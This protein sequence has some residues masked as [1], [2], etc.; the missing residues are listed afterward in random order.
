MVT[1]KKGRAAAQSKGDVVMTPAGQDAKVKKTINKSRRRKATTAPAKAAPE[2][3][4][5]RGR[6]RVEKVAS[7]CA[8]LQE[9]RKRQAE[10]WKSMKAKVAALKKDR[11]KLPTRGSKEKRQAL[12]QDIRRLQE[13]MQVR[14]MAELR[15]A[16]LEATTKVLGGSFSGTLD[17]LPCGF[18]HSATHRTKTSKPTRRGR[19][20]CHSHSTGPSTSA[21]GR[22]GALSTAEV[23]Q[24]APLATQSQPAPSR[25]KVL[26]V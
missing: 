13:D 25:K 4:R 22:H 9:L 8:V 14:H 12:N 26:L 19:L 1:R 21:A 16:G 2:S 7:G 24:R 17:L 5:Q 6:R 3:R 23:R 20:R 11:Q 18:I 15:A 10:E